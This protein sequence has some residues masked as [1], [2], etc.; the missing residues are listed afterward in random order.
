MLRN[1]FRRNTSLQLPIGRWRI[2]QPQNIV[3]EK[4][5]RSNEDHRGADL[6][7]NT[8]FCGVQVLEGQDHKRSG[9][10]FDEAGKNT[11]NTKEKN[12]SDIKKLDFDP[13][14]PFC[15]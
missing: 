1:L 11:K 5:R 4:V 3:D 8:F 10:L 9:S 2:G 12:D 6:C 15:M 14:L 7:Q 13:L